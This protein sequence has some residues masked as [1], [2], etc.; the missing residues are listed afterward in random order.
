MRE[1][2]AKRFFA[3]KQS[4]ELDEGRKKQGSEFSLSLPKYWTTRFLRVELQCTWSTLHGL[5]LTRENCTY[6]SVLPSPDCLGLEIELLHVGVSF[7]TAFILF[8]VSVI[9]EK[10]GRWCRLRRW[11]LV[12]LFCI[13]ALSDYSR[14]WW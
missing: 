7:W 6:L 2:G 8:G 10:C 3:M 9:A 11:L 13:S 14:P 1:D 5:V 4:E 12:L